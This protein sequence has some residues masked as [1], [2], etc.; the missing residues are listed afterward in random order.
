MSKWGAGMFEVHLMF[1][2]SEMIKTRSII[3]DYMEAA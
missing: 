1:D 3:G 2:K